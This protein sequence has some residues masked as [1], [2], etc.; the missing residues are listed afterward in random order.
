MKTKAIILALFITFISFPQEQKTGEIGNLKLVNGGQIT[1]CKVGYRII[2]KMNDEKSNIIVYPTWFSGKSESLVSLSARLFDTTK[3][4][5]IAIDA[6]GN[7]ISSSP[8]NTEFVRNAAFPEFSVKDMVNSQY[9]LLTKVLGIGHIFGI[10]GGSMGGM[11][12]FQWVVSYPGYMDKAIA[13]VGSPE[14]TSFDLMLW[15]AQILAIEQWE[16]DGGSRDDLS[17]LVCVIHN[18]L[19]TTPENKNEKVPPGE[20][21]KYLSDLQGDFRKRFEPYDWKSQLTAMTRHDISINGSLQSAA[22]SI[23]ASFLIIVGS[24]DLIVNPVPALKFAEKYNFRKYVFE[25]NCGH[26]SPGCEFDTFRDV[27]RNFLD[28][29][30]D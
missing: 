17:D 3:Y 27:I 21:D 14:L 5:I 29:P 16:K 12:V 24:Q 2:G 28:E 7:G 18:L 13:Y 23:K 26:L 8:S 19:I 30:L 1:D 25:N 9:Q 4:C 15:R 22:E 20:F 10:I 6:L 11:Q